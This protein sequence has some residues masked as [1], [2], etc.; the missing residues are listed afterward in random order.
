MLVSTKIA[1]DINFF[2]RRKP[3]LYMLPLHR[4][5]LSYPYNVTDLDKALPVH[6]GLLDTDMI[7]IM[8]NPKKLKRGK[9]LVN[10]TWKMALDA[11]LTWN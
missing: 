10:M 3:L 4:S 2:W 11:G 6:Q 8:T 7:S 5:F 1:P 9:K